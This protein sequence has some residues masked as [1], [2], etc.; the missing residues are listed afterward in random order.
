MRPAQV[1]GILLL[2]CLLVVGAVTVFVNAR[3]FMADAYTRYAEKQW[4]WFDARKSAREAAALAFKFMPYN[5]RAL[6]S[7]AV[8]DLFSGS[9]AQALR[10]YE[11]ALHLAPA[12][13]YLWRD[14][15]L[16]LV[17]TGNI[18]DRLEHVVRQAQLLAPRSV[19][20]HESLAYAG[21]KVYTQS[22]RKLQAFWLISIRLAYPTA[23][24]NL[25]LAA[26][27][28]GQELLLCNEVI[29]HPGHNPYSGHNPWC[30]QARWH[31]GLCPHARGYQD[32]TVPD[33][34]SSKRK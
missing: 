29:P 23:W 28:S 22:D 5:A 19:P 27:R 2:I 12:D 34:V 25:L 24:N 9:K 14:Y 30:V 11:Q 4:R 16:A 3:W 15:A 8:S 10:E 18:D 13:A 21:L 31:H 17:Y 32:C 6:K 33:A 26:T 20:L 7:E 1:I